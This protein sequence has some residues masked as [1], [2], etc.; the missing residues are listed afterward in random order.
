MVRSSFSIATHVYNFKI[1]LLNI[2]INKILEEKEHKK[3]Q[4]IDCVTTLD[5]FLI[6]NDLEFFFLYKTF[7]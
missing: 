7:K 4:K 1:L 3:I 5:I 6:S 2:A